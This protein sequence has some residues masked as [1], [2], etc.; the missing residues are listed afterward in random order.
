MMFQH[1]HHLPLSTSYLPQSQYT[2]QW[3]TT[4]DEFLRTTFPNNSDAA[5][6][7]HHKPKPSDLILHYNYGA[8]A[9]KQ[10]GRNHGVLDNRPGLPR[11]Q[12]PEPVARGPTQ[13]VGVCTATTSKLANAHGDVIQQQPTGPGNGGSMGSAAA[14]PVWDEDDVMLF[15]W[16]N[17]MPSMERHTEK[18]RE[19]KANIN[20]WRAGTAV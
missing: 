6:V 1:S 10:W 12:P 20:R 7:S 13:S 4:S 15:F 18:E 17:S 14:Q 3:L 9:V 19:H 2:L 5:F 8:A 16:G 11:F